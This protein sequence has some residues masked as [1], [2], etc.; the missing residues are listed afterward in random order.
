MSQIEAINIPKWGMTMTEGTITEWLVPEGTSI[1]KGQEIL[2]IETTKVTN[3]VKSAASGI[4]RR[5]VLPAGTTAPVGALAGVI[6][7]SSVSD[8]EIAAF[9]ASYANRMDV[10][11]AEGDNAPKTRM[12]K[13]KTGFINVSELGSP[14]RETV[15]FLHGFGGD[16]ST[17]MFNHSR[18]AEGRHAIAVDLPG[19][20]SSSPIPP[21][22]SLLD[23]VDPVKEVIDESAGERVHIV[24]HS[25]GGAIA[26]EL[27][28]QLR[29]RVA[30]LT[31]IAPIGLGTQINREFLR[32]FVSADRRRSLLNALEKL[33]VNSSKITSEMVE[34]T[35]A[36]KRLEG[37]SEGLKAV[38][39]LIADENGQVQ[40][41][42]PKLEAL[43]CHVAL[44]WEPAI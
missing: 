17:W 24:A 27:S 6:A 29:A 1:T 32:E 39:D 33:F 22:S 11:P 25:F 15:V 44:I 42:R 41:I 36:F 40:E 8:N 16:L 35:L 43:N 23:M 5:I 4:L 7:D 31:L 10:S 34:A 30:S 13:A 14:G 28:G 9:V 2:E 19:H 37:V 3:A 18:I 26:A 21:N 20:G 12:V 38:A